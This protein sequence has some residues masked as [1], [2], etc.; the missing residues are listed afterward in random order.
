V[1]RTGAP[2]NTPT[3]IIDK[4]NR[5]INAAFA[6]PRMARQIAEL[7]GTPLAGSPADFGHLT[8]RNRE[9]GQGGQVLGQGRSELHDQRGVT[10]AAA[11]FIAGLASVAGWSSKA[12]AQ[13]GLRRYRV[14]MLDTVCGASTRISARLSRL[15]ASTAISKVKTSPSN[16]DR[17]VAT[18]RAS[19]SWHE[20]VRLDVDVIVTRER[21][22]PRRKAASAQFLS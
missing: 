20:L 3:E 7:G 13:S 6:D 18:T 9:M 21:W 10:N 2:K 4:L 8:P 12:Q 19:L 11:D 22:R 15:C 1:V 16:I 17:P 14:G 5:E